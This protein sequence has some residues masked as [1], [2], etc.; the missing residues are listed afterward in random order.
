MTEAD[1]TGHMLIQRSKT[2]SQGEGRGLPVRSDDDGAQVECAC[3]A[4]Y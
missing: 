4:G 3:E 1:G 2:D